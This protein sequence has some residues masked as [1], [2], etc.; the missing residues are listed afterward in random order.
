MAKEPVLAP[1]VTTSWGEPHEHLV[2][3]VSVV[4]VIVEEVVVENE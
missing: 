1:K 2:P 4:E 3:D